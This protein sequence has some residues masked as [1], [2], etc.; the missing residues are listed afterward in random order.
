MINQINGNLFKLS[1]SDIIAHGVN[2]QGRFASGFAALVARYYP[3]AKQ[4][5]S[6]KHLN[7]GWKIGDIQCCSHPYLKNYKP[8]ICNIATQKYYG[9]D[10]EVYFSYVG[11]RLG[12]SKLLEFAENNK[13]SISMPKIGAGL[14]GGSWDEILTIIEEVSSDYQDV[15]INIYSLEDK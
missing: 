1:T 15:E 14:G 2:C 4:D 5:Y 9:Y 8:I 10:G 6:I 7:D 3:W 11:F 12:L 13:L